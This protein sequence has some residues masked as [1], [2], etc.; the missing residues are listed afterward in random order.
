MEELFQKK[1]TAMNKILGSAIEHVVMDEWYRYKSEDDLWNDSEAD[2]AGWKKQDKLTDEE[3]R[4]EPF[5]EEIVG[6][7]ISNFEK[8]HSKHFNEIF[9]SLEDENAKL[10]K[11]VTEQEKRLKD[12]EEKLELLLAI[13]NNENFGKF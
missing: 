12:L 2:L 6:R 1:V 13:E 3:H 10:K 4:L 7:E 8:Y 5:I 9:A 11:Q